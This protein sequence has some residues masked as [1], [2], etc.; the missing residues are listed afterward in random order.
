V[1]KRRLKSILSFAVFVLLVYTTPAM[2]RGVEARYLYSLSTFSGLLPYSWVSL[3]V[4]KTTSEIYVV[5]GSEVS[6]FNATGMRIYS[7][8]NEESLGAI[9]DVAVDGDGNIFVLSYSNTGDRYSVIRCNF[10]GEPVEELEIKNP[11]QGFFDFRPARIEYQQGSLFLADMHSLRVAVI[12]AGGLF[13]DGYDIASLINLDE[14]ERSDTE[15][16]GFSV[17]RDGN[18]LLTVSVLFKAF[19]ISPRRKVVGFGERGS[20]PGKFSVVAGITSDDR[21]FIYISDKLRCVVMVFDK[22]FR[23]HREFGY[24]GLRPGNLIAPKDLAAD[25]RGKVFVTQSRRRGVSVYRV[26]HN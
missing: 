19:R 8:G 20:L 22:E 1:K 9:R 18:L 13:R 11:P 21:G 10:R 2:A 25:G 5:S 4:D 14:K 17:D 7:F 16:T 24:R 6:I 15:M 12:D 23:F 26:T 3:S